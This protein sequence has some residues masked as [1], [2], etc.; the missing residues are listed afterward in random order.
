MLDDGFYT[1][2]SEM[3]HLRKLW[4]YGFRFTDLSDEGRIIGGGESEQGFPARFVLSHDSSGSN[5]KSCDRVS[6]SP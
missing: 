2:V 5:Q 6:I 1:T 4:M 3:H